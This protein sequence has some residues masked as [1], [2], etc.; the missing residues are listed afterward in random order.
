L[1]YELLV[2]G[3]SRWKA[4]D[5]ADARAWIEE[6]RVEHAE[7]DPEAAHVQV[8]RLSALSWLTGGTMIDREELLR[9]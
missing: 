4:K 8:R 9:P 6:Y 3:R 7:D 5:E 2:D 1:K